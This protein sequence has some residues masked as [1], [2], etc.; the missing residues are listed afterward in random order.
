[1]SYNHEELNFWFNRQMYTLSIYKKTSVRFRMSC[2]WVYS[3]TPFGY[4]NSKVGKWIHYFR[5]IIRPVFMRLC[6]DCIDLCIQYFITKLGEKP[7][8]HE[9][10]RIFSFIFIDCSTFPKLPFSTFAFFFSSVNIYGC[11]YYY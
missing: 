1:M 9:S 3:T 4:T 11:V 7:R 8:F 2:C 10:T 5:L 6:F